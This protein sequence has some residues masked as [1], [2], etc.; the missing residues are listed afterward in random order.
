MRDRDVCTDDEDVDT[1]MG[2]DDV[3]TGDC[4]VDTVTVV[5]DDVDDDDDDD[6]DDVCVSLKI[7]LISFPGM[8][9][10]GFDARDAVS[11]KALHSASYTTALPRCA[12]MCK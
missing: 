11:R 3:V 6:D 1:I 2:D 7:S 10:C 4:T 9:I 12:T 8:A 5:V